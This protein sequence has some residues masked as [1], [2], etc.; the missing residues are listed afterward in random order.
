[1]ELLD[2]LELLDLDLPRT[3][4]LV[5]DRVTALRTLRVEL[6]LQPPV[7]REALLVLLVQL[8]Y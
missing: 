1:M 5:F 3:L 4:A 8:Y 2:L 7:A 6:Q